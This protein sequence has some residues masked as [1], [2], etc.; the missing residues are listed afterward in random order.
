MGLMESSMPY[1][2]ATVDFPSGAPD[3]PA[4]GVPVFSLS[5]L[6]ARPGEVGA[7]VESIR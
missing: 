1:V 7:G 5:V 3:F 2:G 6:F 4:G